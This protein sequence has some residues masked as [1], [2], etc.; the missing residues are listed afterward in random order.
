ME[1]GHYALPEHD[2]PSDPESEDS[3]LS[4]RTTSVLG[5]AV[6][7]VDNRIRRLEDRVA[8]LAAAQAREIVHLRQQVDALAEERRRQ[9]HLALTVAAPGVL[10]L[11]FHCFS[12]LRYGLLPW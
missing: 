1:G 11:V 4:R 3:G 12:L 5:E 6:N 8:A 9:T 2:H 10:I 7:R